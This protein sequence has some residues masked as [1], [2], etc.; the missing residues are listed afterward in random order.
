MLQVVP[1]YDVILFI[2]TIWRN[3]LVSFQFDAKFETR[4]VWYTHGVIGEPIFVPR[5]GYDSWKTGDEDDGYVIVQLYVPERD[6]TEFCIL[7]AKD[8]GKGPLARLKLKHHI[9]YGFHGT[10]TP[11]VF[12]ASPIMK[13]KL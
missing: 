9:P 2:H 1:D 11:E 8:L 5:L 3:I 12:L 13:S 10:F 4:Q 7:D 6:V